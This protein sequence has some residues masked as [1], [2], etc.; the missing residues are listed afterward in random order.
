MVA[1]DFT[2][3]Q[4]EDNFA[5]ILVFFKGS[6]VSREEK[7]V[8]GDDGE[9]ESAAQQPGRFIGLF[10]VVEGSSCGG[11]ADACERLVGKLLGVVPAVHPI[12]QTLLAVA[13]PWV[14]QAEIGRRTHMH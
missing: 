7:E 11:Q 14:Q 3:V 4:V 10:P 1:E 12:A 5:L 9:E 13:G 6:L 8:V 2:L